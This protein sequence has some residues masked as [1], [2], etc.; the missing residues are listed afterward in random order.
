[1]KLYFAVFSLVFIVSYTKNGWG[2]F[3]ENE[4]E[5]FPRPIF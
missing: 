5:I 2:G 4:V 1:M 3:T